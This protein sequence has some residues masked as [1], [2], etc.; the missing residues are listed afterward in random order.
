MVLDFFM[1]GGWVDNGALLLV[2]FV[3]LVEKDSIFRRF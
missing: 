1:V 3:L 2:F